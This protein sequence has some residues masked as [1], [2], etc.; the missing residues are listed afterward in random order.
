MEQIT[1]FIEKYKFQIGLVLIFFI[2]FK[3]MKNDNSAEI[4]KY[5]DNTNNYSN[6]YITNNG[7]L[8][9]GKYVIKGSRNERFCTDDP[10]GVICNRDE[11]GPLEIFTVQHLKG[12]E[13]AIRGQH[14][15]QWCSLTTT[16]M[17]CESPT[18]GDW[19][20]FKLHPLGDGKYGIQSNRNHK[21]CVD[22]GHGLV[23]DVPSMYGWD[24]QQFE[25]IPI[26]YYNIK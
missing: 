17:R 14:S 26:H 20:V 16:G 25:F 12:E 18:V 7:I 2:V 13:Y 9:D 15:G 10:N 24:F 11:P 5:S 22:S 19:E 23:C 3:L 6:N 1:S 4:E 21:W 8:P